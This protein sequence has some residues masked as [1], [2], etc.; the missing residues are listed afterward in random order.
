M[1][2]QEISRKA[3]TNV[4]SSSLQEGFNKM[5]KGKQTYSGQ[6]SKNQPLSDSSLPQSSEFSAVSKRIESI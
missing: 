5:A 1:V 4:I 3:Y 2:T 6:T